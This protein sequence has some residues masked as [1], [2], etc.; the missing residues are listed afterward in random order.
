VL[1]DTL[2]SLFFVLAR[3]QLFDSSLSSSYVV[4]VDVPD[5]NFQHPKFDQVK[6]DANSKPDQDANVIP[7]VLQIVTD[8]ILRLHPI[9]C[10][11]NHGQQAPD[12]EI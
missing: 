1:I 3:V 12:Q 8:R 7:P 5:H 10:K 6:K 9:Y 2:F 11:G 4:L